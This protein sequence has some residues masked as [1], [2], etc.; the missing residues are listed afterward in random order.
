M[1]RLDDDLVDALLG[2]R[3]PR[4]LP[5]AVTCVVLAAP[6]YPES[7]A[8]GD[9]IAEP[10]AD[11]QGTVVFHAGT[12]RDEVGGLRV[13]GGRVLSVVGRGASRD[14]AARTAYARVEAVAWP[15]AQYRRDVGAREAP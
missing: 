14:E 2:A 9:P 7:P 4:W 12:A 1:V 6:G 11:A 13:A 3:Q 8:L 15:G 10:G 5:E